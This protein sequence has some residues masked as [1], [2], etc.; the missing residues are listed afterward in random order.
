M[1]CHTTVPGGA[2]HPTLCCRPMHRAPSREWPARS[3][4]TRVTAKPS[5]LGPRTTCLGQAKQLGAPSL[6]WMCRT[7]QSSGGAAAPRPGAYSTLRLGNAAAAS[8]VPC[9]MPVDSENVINIH[10][11]NTVSSLRI[12]GRIT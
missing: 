6:P 5:T 3:H 12:K 1:D 8:P 2:A 10:T 11:Q 4:T 9:L 7:L